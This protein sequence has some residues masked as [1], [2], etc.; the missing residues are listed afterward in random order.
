V[1]GLL[2]IIVGIAVGLFWLALWA[3]SLRLFGIEALRRQAKDRTVMRERMKR[4]GKFR[5]ILI[6]GV[7]GAGLAFGL[8]LTTAD[9]LEHLSHGWVLTIAKLVFLSVLFGWFQG[10][11]NW[12][13]FKDPVSFPPNYPPPK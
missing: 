1:R 13:G 9:L 11:R 2:S 3:Y 5:Y 12:N 4:M 8:A 7:L 6:F 10:A